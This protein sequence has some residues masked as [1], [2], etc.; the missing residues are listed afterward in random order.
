[1]AFD[2]SEV[3]AKGKL[4]LDGTRARLG[5]NEGVR[6]MHATERKA[7]VALAEISGSGIKILTEW[8]LDADAARHVLPFGRKTASC[9]D[10]MP[11][12]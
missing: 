5:R 2:K 1:M 10:L 3:S 9:Q 11:D 8:I 12:P 7:V 6:K 4:L